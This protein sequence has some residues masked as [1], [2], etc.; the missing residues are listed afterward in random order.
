M[1]TIYRYDLE[2]EHE[3]LVS[4]PRNAEILTVDRQTRF[5]LGLSLWALIDT[6]EPV[7][8]RKIILVGTGTEDPNS[9]YGGVEAKYIATVQEPSGFVWHFF[10]GGDEL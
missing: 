9:A 8:D 5:P 4:L 1:R 7:V 6:A 10:D 3:Q 2:V